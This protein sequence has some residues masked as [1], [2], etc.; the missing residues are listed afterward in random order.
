MYRTAF[1]AGKR[2]Y[3]SS[4]WKAIDS[5][6]TAK[7]TGR[8]IKA[9]LMV[10]R[11]SSSSIQKFSLSEITP[12]SDAFCRRHIG[13]DAE[14]EK[15]MLRTLNLQ[16]IDELID[17]TLPSAIKYTRTLE[18]DEALSEP[19][20]LEKLR[21]L[22]KHNQ[23][24]RSY[25]GM[26]YH[27]CHVP[28]TIL[29]NILENPGWYTSYTPYQPELAQGRLESLLNFQTVVSDLTGLDIAN[30]SLLDEATAAAEAMA[31]CYRHNKKPK[32]FVD[33]NCHPQTISVVQTRAS[34][35]G[36]DGEGLQIIIGDKES[37]DFSNKDVSGVLFQYPDTSGN[38]DDF[39]ELVEK[40][41]DVK[42][43]QMS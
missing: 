14:E 33:K 10:A 30:A 21:Q 34:T 40:A 2:L 39:S 36:P 12:S 19:D 6:F 26:G 25:I 7:S 32:F 27:N 35:L 22:A 29:R 43:H 24:W 28:T 13:P 8:T 1:R 16:N 20:L 42:V 31:L 38:I 18:M 3:A 37:F 9:S 11:C 5:D 17:K 15:E 41:H 4:L 23:I